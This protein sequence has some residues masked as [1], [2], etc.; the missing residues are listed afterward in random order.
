M[1][2]FREHAVSW[3]KRSSLLRAVNLPRCRGRR[4]CAGAGATA[5]GTLPHR[6][7]NN[8][9]LC[10]S[11]AS[12]T[13][14][15]RPP[16][17]REDGWAKHLRG[18]GLER[19]HGEVNRRIGGVG[20]VPDLDS[21][22]R[23]SSSPSHLKSPTSGMTAATSAC[24]CS[25]QPQTPRPVLSELR[26]WLHAARRARIRLAAGVRVDCNIPFRQPTL[27]ATA[28]SINHFAQQQKGDLPSR[29]EPLAL[30]G[31]TA[32]Q[33]NIDPSPQV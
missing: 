5:S 16:G 2:S 23:L 11:S 27:V 18:S 13:C 21:A 19:L 28:L 17:G 29:I 14:S 31:A 4:A 15:P 9:V 20:A 24:P 32:S 26:G 1:A 10:A 33:K 22:L 25:N 6:H 7:L 12:A 30:R 3:L 8:I